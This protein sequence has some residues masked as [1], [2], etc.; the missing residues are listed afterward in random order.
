MLT[1]KVRYF[2]KLLCGSFFLLTEFLSEICLEEIA[3]EIFF[4]ISDTKWR[5]LQFNVDSERRIVW[6]TFSWQFFFL[7]SKF[8]PEICLE[9]IAERNI[10]SYLGYEV[11]GPTV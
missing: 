11:A 2:E 7:L 8:L 9:E 6:E 10:F 4:H 5:D 1:P 3:E